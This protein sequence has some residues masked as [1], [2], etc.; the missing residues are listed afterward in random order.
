MDER[1]RSVLR[2][3]RQILRATE[4]NSK[5]LL[6]ATGLTPSQ[7]VILRMLEENGQMSAGQIAYRLG[8]TQA[9]TTG[10]LHKLEARGLLA[11]RKGE[12]DRRQVWLSLT[13][14]ARALIA[15]TPAGVH[16]RFQ[17][18]FG[19]LE[20]WEQ[21]MLIASLERIAAMLGA[22]DLDVAPLFD[23][24]ALDESPRPEPTLEE[25]NI[26]KGDLK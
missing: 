2:A 6:R 14:T 7:L 3:I 12:H 13:E 15:S 8:I 24:A 10:I 16:E 17:Q 22:G 18:R 23:A 1:T 4:A 20:D 19:E 25:A 26:G 11:R 21:A 5:T 9:T